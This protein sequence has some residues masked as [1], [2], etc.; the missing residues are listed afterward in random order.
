M[1][2]VLVEAF[3]VVVGIKYITTKQ[4]HRR[5]LSFSLPRVIVSLSKV[6]LLLIEIAGGEGERMGDCRIVEL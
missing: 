6:A 2:I 4:S 3:V 5:A 1:I